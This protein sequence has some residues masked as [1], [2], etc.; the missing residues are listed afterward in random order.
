VARYRAQ[1]T[2]ARDPLL[3]RPGYA[4]LEDILLA[5]GLIR[6]R[7]RYEDLVATEFAREAMAGSGRD[8]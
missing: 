1:E 4:Y 7:A 8:P 2:W 5:G 6:R 3:R